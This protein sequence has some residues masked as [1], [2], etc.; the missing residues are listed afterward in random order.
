MIYRLQD[1]IKKHIG[2]QITYN[3]M[4]DILSDIFNELDKDMKHCESI[5][6]PSGNV[7]TKQNFKDLLFK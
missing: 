5:Q 2:V 3:L 7:L 6:L 4:V 1:G